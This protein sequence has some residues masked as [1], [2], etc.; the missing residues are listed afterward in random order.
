MRADLGWRADGIERAT[1]AGGVWLE[2]YQRP[3]FT[4]GKG[5]RRAERGGGGAGFA[6]DRDP[7]PD[8]Y[9]ADGKN[10]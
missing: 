10:A 6:I 5:I 2:V 4:G 3:G 9:E 7:F 8:E 1:A